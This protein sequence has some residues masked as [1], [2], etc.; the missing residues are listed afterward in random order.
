MKPVTLGLTARV[1][2]GS[3]WMFFGTGA[4]AAVQSLVLLV[5]ARLVTP[6]EFGVVTAALIVVGFTSIFSQLG[7]GPALVQRPALTSRHIRVGFT[8]SLLFSSILAALIFLG[9]ARIA[10][11][12][13]I[14][15]LASVIRAI[16]PL[17]ICNGISV[18]AEALAQRELRFRLLASIELGAFAVSFVL[19]GIPLALAG[20]GLWALV[21]AYVTQSLL[22]TTALLRMQPHPKWPLM[23]RRVAAGL[24]YFGNGFTIAKLGNYVAGQADN[25]I[26][27]RWLG[28]QALGLYGQAYQLMT[29]PAL[30]FGQ[31][32]DKV[33]FPA[34]AKVQ[35][36]PDRLRKAYRRGVALVALVTLPLSAILF[37]LAPELIFLLLGPKWSGV[38]V[39][40]RI[41]GVGMLFR[42]S[43]KLSDSV[44]RAT[45]AVY[46][47]AWRQG[48][49]AIAIV[50]GAWF[51]QPWGIGGVAVGVLF[52][53]ILNFVLMAELSLRLIGMTWREFLAVHITALPLTVACSSALWLLAETMRATSFSSPVI[54]AASVCCAISI[55]AICL[56]RPRLFL[57]EEGQWLQ[58]T[59]WASLRPPGGGSS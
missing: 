48:L 19:V 41:L 56:L 34:M 2:S 27:G 49:Y 30:L 36:E 23:D 24:L 10:N 28:P 31:V 47:R 42:T 44:A 17:F 20:Y 57:G 39:P 7:V 32:L 18:V 52:A 21:G 53:I 45:G 46:P 16:S 54:L 9:A 11:F 6:R 35:F 3:L 58:R 33:L 40:F 26:V 5:L 50:V 14:A 25:V 4:Q 1:I 22:R 43:Y 55:G 8:M 59:L 38:V 29:A 12:F 15:E 13:R 51:G 37:V